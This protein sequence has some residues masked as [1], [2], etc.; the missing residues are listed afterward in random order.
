MNGKSVLVFR[1]IGCIVILVFDRF[2]SDDD[3]IGVISDVILVNG[4]L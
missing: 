1:D 2:V 4:S 3:K